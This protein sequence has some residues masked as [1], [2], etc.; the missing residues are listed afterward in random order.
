MDVAGHILFRA[1]DIV[2]RQATSET[3]SATST[4][5][6]ATSASSTASATSTSAAEKAGRP[7]SYKLIGILLAVASGLFIGVSFVVKKKGLLKA[8][9]KYNEEAGEG[10]GY[11]KNLWW[12]SG[13]TLMIVGEICN[14]A[15]YMFV[16]AILVTP[17]GALSVVVTTILSWW[18]LKERLSFVGWVSCFLCIIG[19]VL[20]ALNAPEQSAVSNIQEMQHYVIAPGFLVFAGLI[21]IGCG[22]VAWYVA[23]RW[24]K[25]S[26]MV[27][28]TI[29]SLI[30]GLSVVA[31]QGLGAA[32]IA[33][34][35]GEAQF[36]KWFT[37]V[38]LVFVICT[39]LTE[40]IY[41]NVS[42]PDLHSHHYLLTISQKALNLFNAALVTPTYYVFFTSSTIITSAVLFRGFH[43]TST[44]IINVVFGFLTICSGVVLL[45]LA[46]S[47][48]DV[49]DSKVFSGDLDQ[50]RT[51]AE[52]EEPEYEPRADAIRG[53]AG[54]MRALSSKVR[55][56]RE[57]READEIHRIHEE[58]MEPIG[59]GEQVEWDGLRRRRTVSTSAGG[60]SIVRR[61]TVHPPLGMS[62]FPAEDDDIISEPDS[63]V[64]PG[65]FGRIGR[66]LTQRT[67]NRGHSPVPLDHVPSD[68]QPSEHVLGLPAGLQKSHIIST[69]EDTSYRSPSHASSGGGGGGG[70]HVQWAGPERP[71]SASS[72]LAPP[73]PPAHVTGGG[74]TARRQFSFQN[75][76]SRNRS[77]SDVDRPVSRG[78]LSFASRQRAGSR[79]GSNYPVAQG[80]AATEEERLGLVHGDSR[81]TMVGPSNVPAPA[82]AGRGGI[83]EIDERSSDEWARVTQRGSEGSPEIAGGIRPVGDGGRRRTRGRLSDDEEDDDEDELFDE[84]LR[85][86]SPDEPGRGGGGS[87]RAF[88]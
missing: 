77:D 34:I 64:H 30:G 54:I 60:G 72:S 74:N 26:M 57:Q 84:P 66:N 5:A 76:F 58:R 39:L 59:E 8:N 46:K 9:V 47:A 88:V 16:D 14:F 83:E 31:T 80:G 55:S 38:L 65:F 29:C 13:M 12:W 41:L 28:L 4:I 63:E 35:G 50:M 85:R 6:S 37:Y 22:V 71:D 11:L 7:A 43:G 75:V 82:G 32:I 56:Q 62:S 36:N 44:Q 45:Q 70:G 33:Q 53:G 86:P 51:V 2:V 42:T 18:F 15:A 69:E 48:K 17:L 49:P 81:D 24:G 19:S 78:A 52:V 68:K 10:Y 67:R 79:P 1:A 23:P 87:G 3:A 20:I 40:I 61:K 25:K 27:Y 21:I 73:R